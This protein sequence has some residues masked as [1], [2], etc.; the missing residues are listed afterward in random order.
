[1]ILKENKLIRKTLV[2]TLFCS[3]HIVGN[4]VYLLI[5]GNPSGNPL[6]T[7]I[8]N[9]SNMMYLRY[10]YVLLVEEDLYNYNDRVASGIQGDDNISAVA[11]VISDKYNMITISEALLT[12]G[13]K[14]TNADKTKVD[15]KFHTWQEATFLKRGLRKNLSMA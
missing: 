14:M 11:N 7:D 8:N 4:F 6:T 3:R 10:A 12:I 1:M 5:F 15:V 9:H 13:I 2:A